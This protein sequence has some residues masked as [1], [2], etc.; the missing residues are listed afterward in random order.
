[1]SAKS[2]DL[3]ALLSTA[4]IL[5]CVAAQT[6][7][8]GIHGIA[9]RCSLTVPTTQHL[10]HILEYSNFLR[11]TPDDGFV[12]GNLIPELM[13]SFRDYLGPQVLSYEAADHVVRGQQSPLYE[14]RLID[15]Q[16]VVTH[17][18]G[19]GPASATGVRRFT[20]GETVPLHATA[21]GLALLRETPMSD[22]DRL[23]K[24]QGTQRYTDHTLM[25]GREIATSLAA[26]EF[27][28]VL[29]EHEGYRPNLV[30]V[31]RTLVGPNGRATVAGCAV[32]VDEFVRQGASFVERLEGLTV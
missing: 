7:A 23:L 28:S 1:M 30:T 26:L 9:E 32:P 5:E 19:H 27:G 21:F 20:L 16:L 12:I 25:T 17:V 6:H 2:D 24:Q 4:N 22:W 31:A 14:F 3:Q 29:V 11:R 15:R 13:E 18:H 10:V 8:V